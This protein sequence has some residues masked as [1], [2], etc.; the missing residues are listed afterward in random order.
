[1]VDAILGST[2]TAWIIDK[3]KGRTEMETGMGECRFSK[4]SFG[5]HNSNA[6]PFHLQIV[7]LFCNY[8]K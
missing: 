4:T 2:Q 3:A 7:I 8:F 5:M 6:L 1:M